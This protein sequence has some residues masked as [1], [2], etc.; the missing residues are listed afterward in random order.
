M[1]SSSIDRTQRILMYAV[2]LLMISFEIINSCRL[3]IKEAL[4]Y[5]EWYLPVA[6]A[7]FVLFFFVSAWISATGRRA[8]RRRLRFAGV[9]WLGW[10]VCFGG[11]IALNFVHRASDAYLLWTGLSLTV[12]PACWILWSSMRGGLRTLTGILS[13][14]MVAGSFLFILLNFAI[15]PFVAREPIEPLQEYLGFCSHPNTN[16]ILCGGFAAAALF[17]LL[18]EKKHKI[19]YAV[20]LGFSLSVITAANCRSAE[21][22]LILAAAAGLGYYLRHRGLPDGKALKKAVLCILLAAAVCAASFFVLRYI[23]QLTVG[24]NAPAAP[25]PAV[26]EQTEEL[27]PQTENEQSLYNLVNGLSS[28]RLTIW[29]A[30]IAEIKPFGN[31]RIEGLLTETNSASYSAHNNVLEVFYV[32]GYIPGA[33]IM[34]WMLYCLYAIGRGLIRKGVFRPQALFF[35]LS[36][37]MFFTIS[38]LEIMQYPF[39]RATSLMAYLSLGAVAF[40]QRNPGLC[41]RIVKRLFDFLAG[42]IGCALL[43]PVMICVKAAQSLAGDHGPLLYSQTRIGLKGRPFR[44]YKFR[45]MVVGA[46]DILDE[47]M[48]Q[49]EYRQQWEESQ[50]LEDDPRITRLGKLLRRTSI[51]ELPQLLNVLKGDMSLVGPRPLVPGELESHGGMRLYQEA[52]PGMTGWWICHGHHSASYRKRLKLEYYYVLNRSLWLDTVCVLMTIAQ[53]FGESGSGEDKTE[54]I[55]YAE[56][57]E[58]TITVVIPTL[59]AEKYLPTLLYSLHRQHRR[60]DEII[61]VDSSST[62]RTQEICAA[63]PRVRMIRIPREEFDHGGSRDMAVRRCDGDIVV[64]LTQDALPADHD[65]L[66]NLIAPLAAEDVAVSTGR[67]IARGRASEAEKLIREYNYPDVSFIRSKE[68]QKRL[69]IKTYFVSNVCSAYRRDI[70]DELGGFE[71]GLKTNEDM[72]FAAKAIQAGYKIAYSADAVV[73]H[74]H[75][76][77]WSEQY[78]RNRLQGYEIEKHAELLGNAPISAEGKKM[79]RHVSKGLLRRGK[80]ASAAGFMVDCSARYLGSRRGRRQGK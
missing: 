13:K 17:L 27:S 55:P 20:S 69:G 38:M 33:G 8:G 5:T 76:L 14:S 57:F 61:V 77:T 43:L 59:N 15:T 49:D 11:I 18:T 2:M 74:S 64:F 31:G 7:L 32:S 50:K 56:D 6:S 71:H 40:R 65:F 22:G 23:D 9:F 58:P 36:F 1:T 60:A 79:V 52:R 21:L 75:D 62:D 34:L 44:I 63:D 30:C 16:G 73:Y 12:I 53:L 45:T 10:L 70:Y 51:D 78:E 26:T 28:D 24:G 19:L 42:I 3:A 67:Q 66:R 41:Y 54:H 47:L 72:F 68:D 80:F 25:A 37:M 35:I 48:D 4:R 46:E 39:L 29:T